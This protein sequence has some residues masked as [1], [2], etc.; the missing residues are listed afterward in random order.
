MTRITP[1]LAFVLLTALSSF[2]QTSITG[3]VVDVD[4]GSKRLQI[5]TDTER[6]RLTVETDTVAT[7]YNG[8]GTVIAGKPEIFVG[9]KGF[10]NVR[11]DD[12]ISIRGTTRGRGVIMA[13]DV[14]LLGRAVAANP[15]GVGDTRSPSSA[16]TQVD[17]RTTAQQTTSGGFAEGTVRQINERE[18]RIVIQTPQ[19]RLITVNAS[20]NTPVYYRGELYRLTNLEVGDR[21]RVEADP[22]D[23]QA[24]EISAIRIDVLQDVQSPEAAAAGSAAT[25]TVIEGRVTRVDTTQ[26]V[27]WIQTRDQ[28]IR[29]DMNRAE[30]DDGA[31]MGSG[32][33]RVGDTVEVTGSFNRVG[34]I[35]LAS[36]VRAPNAGRPV[37]D[38]FVRY[39]VVTVDATVVETLQDAT[40]LAVRDRQGNRVVRLWVTEDF[41]VRLKAGTTTADKL[42][43]DDNLRIRAFRDDF[44]N[45]VAQTITVRNR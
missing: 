16:T 8:F 39:G 20:R 42:R 19:R 28:E 44:G 45:L 36:T 18:N 23:A 32:D 5:E 3:T 27:A 26:N 15:V 38:E 35:F 25:V 31:R 11:L 12:R 1:V 30:G 10:S 4:E 40:T 6:T 33:V 13:T 7:Q 34:D 9:S 14:T 21:I 17:R 22:R 37:V 43:V 29:V 41:I 2:A 24:D